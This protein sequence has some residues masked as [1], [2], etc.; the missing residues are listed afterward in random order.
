VRPDDF[1][2]NRSASHRDGDHVATRAIDRFAHCFGDFV[3]L[4]RRET[5]AALTVTDGD[6]SVERKATS[7][8]HDFGDAIDGD[9]VLDELA[10]AFSA[11]AFAIARLAVT[12]PATASTLTFATGATA[13]AT[14][15]T[16]TAASTTST[17]TTASAATTATA[18]ATAA[19]PRA[20]TAT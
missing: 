17:G 18:S 5:D 9:D 11:A 6:E 4:A 7:A 15:S 3:G 8:L 10:A 2:R 20:T 19:A 13:L 1:V 16:A 14:T 12:S